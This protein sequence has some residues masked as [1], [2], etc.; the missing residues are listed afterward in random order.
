NSSNFRPLRGEVDFSLLGWLAAA[1]TRPR[2]VIRFFLFRYFFE[3]AFVLPIDS[4]S[5]LLHPRINL[6]FFH[7][8][9]PWLNL[10]LLLRLWRI[11]R[12]RLT[13]E[14]NQTGNR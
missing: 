2:I 7:H 9:Q 5:V 11:L 6:F 4:F 12:Y 14:G 10:R 1:N 8:I 13:R 3:R